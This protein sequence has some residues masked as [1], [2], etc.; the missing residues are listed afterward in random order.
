MD[1]IFLT[2][3]QRLAK[4]SPANQQ[5]FIY[6]DLPI[7]FRNQ[8]VFIW[9]DAIG[10]P[11]Q[12]PYAGIFG[13]STSSAPASLFWGFVYSAL[14]D[15]Y[16]KTRLTLTETTG[17]PMEQCFAFM[18]LADLDGALDIIELAF[19]QIPIWQRNIG[20]GR[21][22]EGVVY[23]GSTIPLGVDRQL[24]FAD[25]AIKRLNSRFAQH[26]LGYEFVNNQ[27][28]R[29][30]S[31]FIHAEVTHPALALLHTPGFAGP[32]E[33]FAKAHKHYTRADYKES[34]VEGL[35]A[36]ESTLKA[37]FVLRNWFFDP[38]ATASKLIDIAFDKELIPKYLQSEFTSFKAVLVN[39]VPTIR[40]KGGGHGQG[41]E[42]VPLPQYM[43]AYLL[44]LTA[45]N[46]VL[47]INAH[48]SNP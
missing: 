4:N 22:I 26:H 35:K 44:H 48:Q 27:V 20:Y 13:D 42:I 12:N 33:E 11:A 25:D 38:T 36:F 8:V 46:I 28:L 37:I 16:G 14:C 30:D 19:Q 6:D 24:I 5:D 17:K 43:A 21:A 3:S 15:S 45:A 41:S 7:E 34:A 18:Q 39:G 9:R 23:R 2:R 1:D 32:L 47:L 31:Q 40:N 10:L 29:K